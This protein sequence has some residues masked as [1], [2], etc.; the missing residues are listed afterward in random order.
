MIFT[1]V[2]VICG[3]L[4]AQDANNAIETSRNLRILNLLPNLACPL[5]VEPAIPDNFVAMSRSGILDPYDWIYWGPKE[6]IEAHFKDHDSLSQGII[7]IKLSANVMQ[8]GPHEFDGETLQESIRSLKKELGRNVT[9]RDYNWGNYPVRAMKAKLPEQTFLIAWIGL[10]DPSGWTLM[11]N[12]IYPPKGK[13][14]A[15]D[16]A[17]WKNF[18]EK[19]TQLPERDMILASGQ[20]LQQDH[21][22]V[23]LAGMKFKVRAEKRLSDGCL[24]IVVT[25][26]SSIGE[27]VYK[28]MFEARLGTQW[29]HGAPIVKVSASLSATEGNC[30][31]HIDYVVTALIKEVQ[32]FTV[33][34][35]DAEH[36]K[37]Q[38]V[39]QK[40]I[41]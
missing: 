32:E 9:A 36:P 35:S 33:N 10:N 30:T 22:L 19:T 29:M 1:F 12:M 28:D 4:Q 39:Y 7:R 25:R 24:Q 15:K 37:D 31:N 27:F 14:K 20:D 41:K 34:A 2:F 13:L 17:L 3:V 8:T 5:G 16:L 40:Q 6:V 23:S 21:T 26:L 38:F 18:L 11:A